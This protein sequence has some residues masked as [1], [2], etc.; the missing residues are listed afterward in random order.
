MQYVHKI[1]VNSYYAP[2]GSSVAAVYPDYATARAAAL[3]YMAAATPKPVFS[4]P[5]GVAG[6]L[7]KGIRMTISPRSS[8]T[9]ALGAPMFDAWFLPYSKSWVISTFDSAYIGPYIPTA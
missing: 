7:F 2:A 3:K 5:A 1:D 4:V 6:P 8:P 9:A